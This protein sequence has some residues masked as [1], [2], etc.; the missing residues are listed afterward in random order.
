M[1]AKRVALGVL[2][3]VFATVIIGGLQAFKV[4]DI[5]SLVFFKITDG[6]SSSILKVGYQNGRG[7]Q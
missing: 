3:F 5:N 6:L 1:S 4:F 7:Y 2:I